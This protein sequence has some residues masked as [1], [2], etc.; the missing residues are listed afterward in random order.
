VPRTDLDATPGAAPDPSGPPVALVISAICGTGGIGKTWLALRWAHQNQDR[1][2]DGQLYVNLRGFDPAGEPLPAAVA[3][4][5]FLDALGVD[6][7]AIPVEPADQAALYRSLVAGK[8]M[9]IVADNARDSDQVLP[10]LPG[11][12]SCAVLITSRHRLPGLVTAHGARP[13]TLDVLTGGEARRLLTDQLGRERVAA[14]PAAVDALLDQC[15]GLPLALRIAAARVA[16]QPQLPLA[17]LADELRAASTRLD[18]LNAGELAVNLR[19]VLSCSVRVLPAAAA[20]LFALLG[21]A[22]GADIGLAAV[23]SLSA[24]PVARARV[25]LR[26]LAGAN[27]VHEPGPGRYRMHD[28]VRLYAAEQATSR[29]DDDA[30]HAAVHRLLDHYLRT[31][32]AADRLLQPH[33]D[34]IEPV[35]PL[36]GARPRTVPDHGTA[37]AWF[38]AEHAVLLAAIDQAVD[39][40]LD[41][42]AWQLAW[43][44][45]TYFDRHGHWHD[46]AATQRTALAAARRLADRPA[47][48]HAHRGL[49]LAYVWLGRYTEAGTELG[50]ALDL[51]GQLGDRAGQ[52][53]AHRAL[54]R[55]WARQGRH[56]DALPHDLRALELYQAAGHRAGQATALNAVGWHH[57]NL[58]NDARA[59]GY[60]ER[61]RALHEELGDWHGAAATWD[62]LGYVYHHLGQ[63]PRAVS[64][65]RRAIELFGQVGDRYQQ[66]DALIHLGDAANAA[67]ETGLARQSW[68]A[69]LNTLEELGHPDGRA[70][71]TKLAGLDRAGPIEGQRP[72]P[73]RD[74][75]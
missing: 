60:C 67:G 54:A 29:L 51:F 34:P 42:H 10:L 31:A 2:A 50:G 36:P 69:A 32:Y 35:P 7:A 47:Q 21:L 11:T 14:E 24:L 65:Y 53:H 66:A 70:V 40:G 63:L 59:L 18:G 23:A 5:G 8:R 30:R 39:A 33:R 22:A 73:A 64:C 55:M 71:R 38:T 27:L 72:W 17:A 75:A 48:A 43:S 19:A 12:P 26:E 28:L 57:A 45:I 44:L 62:S 58:G 61:A 6:P 13:L 16:F 52:A 49:G 20:D 15:A 1:F 74:S 9:L 3:V 37:L 68:R 46:R 4:R 41:R 25:L 56:H